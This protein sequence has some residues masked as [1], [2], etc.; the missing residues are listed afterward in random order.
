MRGLKAHVSTV[1]LAGLLSLL[2]WSGVAAQTDAAARTS[3]WELNLHAAAMRPALFDETTQALQFGGRIFRNFANGISIGGNVDWAKANDV[4]LAPFAGLGASLLLYSAELEY[5]I[6]VSPRST[7]FVAAGVGAA[8][9][10]L[11]DAP[12]GAAASSTGL[13]VPAGGGVKIHNRAVSPSW[14][15]RFDLR[16]NVILLETLGAD[17]T[18]TEPRHN[19]EASVGVSFLF[20]GRSAALAAERDSD[21]D[22]VPDPRD[23]CLNRAGAPVDARGC[24][25]AEADA[26]PDGV[27][28]PEPEV[29][30]A[31]LD[32][33]Q[34]NVPDVQDGCLGTP[35]GIQVGIDGCPLLPGAAVPVEAAVPSGAGDEDGDGVADDVDGCPG[36]PPGIPTDD[37]GCLARPE[38]A[39]EAPE[40][41][42][43]AAPV[44]APQ[45]GAV[46][47]ADETACLDPSEG[48]RA[49]EFDG[50]R[51]EPA[52]FP[53]PVDRRFLIRVGAFEGLQIYVSDTAQQPYGDFWVPRC[54]GDGTFE[55]YVETGALP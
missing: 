33:D 7:F 55:L 10:S 16:D 11:D 45:A 6:P 18:E 35:A 15:I 24:P 37:R 9:V 32:A 44:P 36:T 30:E 17:G 21:R 20:G 23:F 13:L 22:G 42:A 28:R 43:I 4:T 54:G 47:P 25:L 34:D 2:S 31:G 48:R 52:G 40:D 49:I 3:N 8:T 1:A 12:F 29:P 46:G 50:R 14:A 19:I 39:P 27:Q 5:G 38:P 51:F 53:Q 26:D 41:E